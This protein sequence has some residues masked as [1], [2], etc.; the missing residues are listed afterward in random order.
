MKRIVFIITIFTIL[1]ISSCSSKKEL[2]SLRDTI[3]VIDSL[4]ITLDSLRVEEKNIQFLILS[5]IPDSLKPIKDF[6][7]ILKDKSGNL[8]E[9]P[10]HRSVEARKYDWDQAYAQGFE[11]FDRKE[12]LIK[13]GITPKDLKILR[14][15]NYI[16]IELTKK[17]IGKE[18]ECRRKQLE[19]ILR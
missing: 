18:K 12:V 16:N 19:T 14:D 7:F 5:G 2:H 8:K 4:E 6:I 15:L 17:K 3:N 13:S 1:F 10:P 9:L 11:Y